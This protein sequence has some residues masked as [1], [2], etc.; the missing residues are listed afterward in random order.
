M[1]AKLLTSHRRIDL[2]GLAL[3]GLLTALAAAKLAALAVP[4]DLDLPALYGL[5]DAR[6]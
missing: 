6:P 3:L 4:G 5:T 1:S 2:A